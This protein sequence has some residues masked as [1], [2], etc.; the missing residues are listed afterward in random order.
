VNTLK[1]ERAA[2]REWVALLRRRRGRLFR[3]AWCVGGFLFPAAVMAIALAFGR[4]TP[5]TEV[6]LAA[7]AV[8]PDVL[9]RWVNGLAVAHLGAG[10]LAV[11]VWHTR[12]PVWVATAAQFVCLLY[13]WFLASMAVQGEY[14]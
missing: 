1:S 5:P 3:I 7:A 8:H 2:A 13:W 10:T 12:W 14:F 11:A 6:D 9:T 4:Q